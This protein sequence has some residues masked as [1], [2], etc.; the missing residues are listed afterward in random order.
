MIVAEYN[1]K[2]RK[3]EIHFIDRVP[4]LVQDVEGITKI[5]NLVSRLLYQEVYGFSSVC[6]K[7]TGKCTEN[8]G[9]RIESTFSFV[10][11]QIS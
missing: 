2:Q 10:R 1:A 6:W 8:R 4:E 9:F 3:T 7:S 5:V 11:N